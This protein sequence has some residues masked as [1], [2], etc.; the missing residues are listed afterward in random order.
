MIYA[1]SCGRITKTDISRFPLRKKGREIP[2][3]N[4]DKISVIIPAYQPDEKL[5]GVIKGLADAGIGDIIVVNDGSSQACSGVFAAAKEYSQVTLLTH[6]VNRGKGAALRTAFSYFIENRPGHEG[7]VTADADGQHIAADI[8][9]VGRQMSETGGVVLGVRDFN[10]PDVPPRSR[11]GNKMTCFAFRA[12]IGL[13]CSD[14]QTGL[15]AIPRRYMKTMLSVAGDRYEYETNMLIA[16][17]DEKIP[18]SEHTINTV[19]IEDNRSSHFRPVR[20]SVRI[21]SIILKR[22]FKY[23]ASSV[24]CFAVEQVIQTSVFA[25]VKESFSQWA[26]ELL[27]FGPARIVSS[28]LNYFINRK[29]VFGSTSRGA[30]LRYY[31]LVIAQ[32][33]VTYGID[34][35]ARSLLGIDGNAA[36]TVMTIIVKVLI[37]FVSYRIQKEWVF[38]KN[39]GQKG[40]SE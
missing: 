23:V 33:A 36:Y 19:Y 35:G 1:G 37:A 2:L 4:I 27:S 8:I 11:F 40:A 3:D 12:F 24:G 16:I 30:M 20:D 6:E 38:V 28:L 15:R 26:T 13:K 25:A 34:L 31:A 9:A 29:Y 32:A 7:A 18:I 22:F 10:L 39:D 5:L 17:K 21:Y 14:T